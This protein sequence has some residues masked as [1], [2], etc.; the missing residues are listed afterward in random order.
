LKQDGLDSIPASPAGTPDMSVS[1][2]DERGAARARI[3]IRC[4]TKNLILL[5]VWLSQE[6]K[7]KGSETCLFII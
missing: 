3:G 7:K 4:S 6:I 1:A 2:M 5:I